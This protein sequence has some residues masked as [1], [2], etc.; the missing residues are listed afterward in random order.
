MA[1]ELDADAIV[2]KAT[3]KETFNVFDFVQASNLPT[4][5]VVIYTDAD[6]ALKLAKIFT[7]EA[8]RAKKNADNSDGFS[9]ADDFDEDATSEEVITELHARLVATSLTFHLKGLAPS[10]V[11]AIENHIKATTDF[12]EGKE[13]EEFTATFNNTLIV[14]S[15]VSVERTDGVLNTDAWTIEQVA[16]FLPELFISEANKIY[17][18]VAEINY[19]GAIFDRAVNADFS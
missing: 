18:G 7:A 9:L 6:A 2:E 1:F 12:K 4:S 16:A 19:I 13:N 5:D 17:E 10:A 15:I 8:E 11:R 14:K 3:S